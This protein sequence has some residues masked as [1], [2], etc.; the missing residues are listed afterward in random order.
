[1][2]K[3]IYII[4]VLE[5]LRMSKNLKHFQTYIQ[6][7]NSM[8]QKKDE[9]QMFDVHAKIPITL[10]EKFKSTA[11]NFTLW[12]INAMEDEVYIQNKLR[13]IKRNSVHQMGSQGVVETPDQP[14]P[15]HQQTQSDNNK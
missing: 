13:E 14:H 12:L 3:T 10:R 2:L 7:V 6:W 5:C 9:E 4:D 15:D 8:K 11:L 1:M